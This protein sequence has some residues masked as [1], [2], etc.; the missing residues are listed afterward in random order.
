MGDEQNETEQWA[1]IQGHTDRLEELEDRLNVTFPT[2]DTPGGAAQRIRLAVPTPNSV[3]TIGAKGAATS[4][5]RA[6]GPGG[7]G[8]R[9]VEN[10]GVE[11]KGGT[12]IDTDGLTVV[13][14]LDALRLLTQADLGIASSGAMHIGTDG[15][16]LELTAGSVAPPDPAFTVVPDS[17]IPPAGD[18]TVDTE[19]PR[20]TTEL[21]YTA[22]SGAW[23]VHDVASALASWSSALRSGLTSG[24]AAGELSS[25]GAAFLGLVRAS[26]TVGEAL[27]DVAMAAATAA[28]QRSHSGVSHDPAVKVHGAG[29]VKITS[30]DKV[31]AFG[32]LGVSLSSPLKVSIKAGWD[33]SLKAVAN[34]KVYG[35]LGVGIKSLG[36]VGIKGKVVSAGGDFVEMKA[37]KI[38]AVCSKEDLMLQA[39]RT[40]A[41]D[42][43]DVVVGAHTL[44]LSARDN[45]YSNGAN[46]TSVAEEI[47]LLGGDQRTRV[48][49]GQR[50]DIEV[51]D[52][53]IELESRKI[54]MTAGTRLE[55]TVEPGEIK[56]GAVTCR[57]NETVIRGRVMLG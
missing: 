35:A 29:G 3:L 55:L 19:S 4:E 53:K 11:I 27:F 49:S 1:E 12:C 37:Q 10:L 57:R 56:A 45:L 51:D 34:A 18:L 50:I 7:F 38:A 33:A 40:A 28:E 39:K 42:A 6:I 21:L 44:E 43:P 20:S 36:L 16:N 30:P 46:I 24:V 14:S 5:G 41:L 23:Q 48:V 25:R 17:K 15:G 2:P 47:H 13:H 9:T 26:W 31:S 32:A 52:T 22:S 54:R 8:L